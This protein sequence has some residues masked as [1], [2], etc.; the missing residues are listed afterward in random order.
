MDRI[1]FTQIW[2]KVD[3]NLMPASK[4]QQEFF[5]LF[6]ISGFRNK[7]KKV[8]FFLKFGSFMKQRLWSVNH[9]LIYNTHSQA[10]FF[11]LHSFWFGLMAAWIENTFTRRTSSIPQGFFS[12][13]ILNVKND[14]SNN[15]QSII[16]TWP[17]QKGLVFFLP[18]LPTAK[19]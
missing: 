15:K 18:R 8:T 19:S 12:F 9:F 16:W 4:M 1:F 3:K 2:K 5:F 13:K 11:F 7:Q 14:F 10:H 17:K 6:I